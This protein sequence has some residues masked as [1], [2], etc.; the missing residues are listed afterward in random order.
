MNGKKICGLV[1]NVCSLIL[2]LSLLLPKGSQQNPPIRAASVQ[3]QSAD[4]G[5]PVPPR[6]PQRSFV[7]DGGGPVS[8]LPPQAGLMADGGGPV[9]PRPPQFL[10]TE[11]LGA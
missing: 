4:G 11:L 3:I 5:G 9:P 2:G 8:P 7:A 6:P 1:L 10:K